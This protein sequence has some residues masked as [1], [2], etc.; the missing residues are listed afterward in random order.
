MEKEESVTL[1]AAALN[2]EFYLNSSFFLNSSKVSALPAP[3]LLLMVTEVKHHGPRSKR[4]SR[5]ISAYFF[6]LLH[7]IS[8]LTV[9]KLR[10]GASRAGVS[11][12]TM[13]LVTDQNPHRGSGR[14]ISRSEMTGKPPV[15]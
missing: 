5:C 9:T 11:E 6:R 4:L 8:C 2:P 15:R 10:V 7:Q 3:L 14:F 13:F 1:L 12:G